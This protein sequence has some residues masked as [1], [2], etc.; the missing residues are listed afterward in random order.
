MEK[1]KP[2]KR[3]AALADFSR[4]H[5]IALLLLWKI[6]EGMK[7]SIQ[8]ARMGKYVVHFFESELIPHFKTEEE[9][10]FSRLPVKRCPKVTGR[11]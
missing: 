7:K 1:L 9:L 8:P 3:N 11:S 6:R 5:H 4:D 2:L 10:L